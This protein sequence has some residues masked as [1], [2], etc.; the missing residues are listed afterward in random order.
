MHNMLNQR[1]AA[2]I[3]ANYSAARMA[4]M[5][6]M[7]FNQAQ[8]ASLGSQI[9]ALSGILANQPTP[10]VIANVNLVGDAAGVFRQVRNQNN[11]YTKMHGKSA[12][13]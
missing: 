3:S 2:N 6:Q 12:F 10:E 8:L 1:Q 4:E 7:S 11:V 9:G 13:A 5:E